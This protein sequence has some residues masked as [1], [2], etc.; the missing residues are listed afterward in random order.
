MLIVLSGLKPAVDAHRVATGYSDERNTFDP[1]MDMGLGKSTELA[2]ESIPGE[3]VNS[4][5]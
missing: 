1:L 5:N 2:C 4:I 3:R